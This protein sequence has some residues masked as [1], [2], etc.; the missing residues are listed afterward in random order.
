MVR[1]E[2]VGLVALDRSDQ[3]W[4]GSLTAGAALADYG[5]SRGDL[6]PVAAITGLGVGALQAL[7]LSR[8]PVSGALWW[9]G[10]EPAGVGTW[11]AGDL[12]RD[13][14]KRSRSVHELWREWG[15]GLRTADLA[16]PHS[17]VPRERTRSH[18]MN[19]QNAAGALLII[20][21][22]AFNLFFFLLARRFDYPNI[23]RSPTQDVS[24]IDRS[25]RHVDQVI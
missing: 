5:V 7:V 20:L 22:V 11:L 18:T 2:A 6:M 24:S 23:L 9:G 15:A 8:S 16:P 17:L 4:N 3:Q 25:A 13:H 10:R 19:I 12:L 14:Q 21:P 1:P